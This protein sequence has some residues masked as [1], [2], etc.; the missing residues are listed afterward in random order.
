MMKITMTLKSDSIPGSGNSIAGVIDRDIVYDRFGLPYIP[1]KRLKGI[2]RESAEELRNLNQLEFEPDDLFGKPGK[3]IGAEFKLSNGHIENSMEYRTLLQSKLVMD[4]PKLLPRQS[5]LEHFTYTRT[6]TKIN[7]E[8]IAE[9]GSLR[10][11]RVLKAGLRFEFELKCSAKYVKDLEKICSVTR[12]FGAS[13]NR[14]FGEI[15]L[16]LKEESDPSSG[17]SNSDSDN[18]PTGEGYS[19]RVSVTNKQQLLVSTSPGYTDTSDSYISGSVLIG[20][21]AWNYIRQVGSADDNFYKLFLSGKISFG[22]LYPCIDKDESGFLYY[23]PPL[24]VRKV[25]TSKEESIKPG[26]YYDLT[27]LDPDTYKLTQFKGGLSGFCT[28]DAS[29]SNTYRSNLSFGIE[30]H[31]ARPVDRAKAKPFNVDGSKG[32]GGVFYQYEVIEPDQVFSGEIYGDAESLQKISDIIRKTDKFRLGKSRT[33]QYGLCSFSVGEIKKTK[34]KD[35]TW[36]SGA[37]LRIILKSNMVLLNE[38]GFAEP[39]IVNF[40]EEFATRFNIDALDIEIKKSFLKIVQTGGFVGVWGMPRIQ[41]PALATGSVIVLQN[42]SSEDIVI[43]NLST[44]LFGDRIAEG[45]GRIDFY[46]PKGH[47]LSFGVEIPTANNQDFSD[48]LEHCTNVQKELIKSRAQEKIE[49]YLVK[50]AICKTKKLKN[51]KGSFLHKLLGIINLCNNNPDDA[52]RFRQFEE[53]LDKFTDKQKKNLEAIMKSLCIYKCKKRYKVDG[54]KFERDLEKAD[55][56]DIV[57]R[58][59]G[60][61]SF[62]NYKYYVESALTQ[63]KLNKR[64]KSANQKGGRT[65]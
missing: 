44:E 38:N 25:K 6:Q 14:G 48:S 9:T 28:L 23:P 49:K 43:G 30:S 42:Q 57:K 51:A 36:N 10:T 19:M 46:E 7:N 45:Y 20:A 32:E 18:T 1:S 63:L 64:K 22:N 24:S 61:G 65:G 26:D 40:K 60:K 54:E 27:D 33:S 31:H 13:R 55:I 47:R 37:E 56:P 11:S 15:K 2:L 8:G 29:L 5:V 4:S 41:Q 53:Y 12:A 35:I 39:S 3:K 52:A 58:E 34:Q 50:I 16:E 21:L 62:D 59:Y 17:N